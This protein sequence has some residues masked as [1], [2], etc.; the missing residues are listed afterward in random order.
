MD[1]MKSFLFI[2]LVIST[3]MNCGG[4]QSSDQDNIDGIEDPIVIPTDEEEDD[5]QV[6]NTEKLIG[7]P[8]EGLST[9]DDFAWSFFLC[10]QY[11]TVFIDEFPIKIFVAFFTKAEEGLIQEGIDVA[12]EAM[13]FVAYELTNEW[14]D[15]LR[16]IYKVSEIVRENGFDPNARGYTISEIYQFNNF[17]TAR[18]Q[19]ADWA[20]ELIFSGIRKWTVAHELGHASGIGSHAL[21]DYENDKLLELEENSLMRVIRSDP[22]ALT[23]YSFMMKKQAEI[24]QDHLGEV[25]QL[26]NSD[27]CE[28]N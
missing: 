6:V 26:S 12:N 9:G 4:E 2:F 24:M 11:Q 8:F 3:L 16:V 17:I 22:P 20:I 7:T 28:S 21:I 5:S 18:K 15:R 1:K 14:N 23:D 27:I 10:N 25:G 13:G 19:N